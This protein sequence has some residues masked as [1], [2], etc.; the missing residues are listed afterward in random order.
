MDIAASHRCLVAVCKRAPSVVG[1]N[2][3]RYVLKNGGFLRMVCFRAPSA[4]VKT[5]R[6]DP[7]NNPQWRSEAFNS[8]IRNK[9]F[10][11]L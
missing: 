9:S 1:N 8:S 4:R 10:A 5:G 11:D 6:I 2:Y 7:T 3:P